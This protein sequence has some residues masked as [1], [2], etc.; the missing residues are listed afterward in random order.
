L[1]VIPNGMPGFA[2]ASSWT[3]DAASS[4]SSCCAMLPTASTSP[5][6]KLPTR[7]P[8]SGTMRNSIRSK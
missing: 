5:D 7:T 6:A 4:A 8:D 1:K 3:P 2:L